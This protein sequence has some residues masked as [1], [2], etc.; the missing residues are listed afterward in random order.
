MLLAGCVAVVLAATAAGV[1]GAAIDADEPEDNQREFSGRCTKEMELEIGEWHV[2]NIP[3]FNTLWCS[4]DTF[5]GKIPVTR[6]YRRILQHDKTS[7][8]HAYKNILYWRRVHPH[9]IL[10]PFGFYFEIS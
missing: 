7:W 8:L 6:R 10:V 5:W 9:K 2:A 1:R 3:S 4:L